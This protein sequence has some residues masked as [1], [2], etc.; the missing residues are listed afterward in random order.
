M[1][2]AAVVY[3]E[4]LRIGKP[5]Q[6]VPHVRERVAKASQAATLHVR[7]RSLPAEIIAAGGLDPTLAAALLLWVDRTEDLDRLAAELDAIG[8]RR[9][10]Y[11]VVESVLREYPR[12]DWPP[13][14]ASP[15]VT[16]FA[17][18]RRRGAIEEQEFHARWQRHSTLSLRHHPLTRYHRNAVLRRLGP[19][20]HDCDGIVEE[21]VASL[22]DL[23]PERFYIGDGVREA[24][25]ASLDAY[26]DLAAGGLSCGLM[27]EYLVK[28]PPWVAPLARGTDAQ[29]S[30]F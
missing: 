20:P 25:I 14:E 3:R 11:L 19:G 22:A 16:L 10:T 9:D 30:S 21:R 6:L 23:A 15:G 26:V 8:P 4:P 17:L 24:A 5:A 29:S 1:Q 13:S 2:K 7:S 27:D 12:I 18:L 28:L